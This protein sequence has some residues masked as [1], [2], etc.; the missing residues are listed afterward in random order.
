MIIVGVTGPVLAATTIS[1][2]CNCDLLAVF[3]LGW[4]R[5]VTIVAVSLIRLSVFYVDGAVT[6]AGVSRSLVVAAT[7][8]G[9]CGHLCGL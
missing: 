2:G 5:A 3:F 4:Q 6:I 8:S 7:I 1:W 9:G